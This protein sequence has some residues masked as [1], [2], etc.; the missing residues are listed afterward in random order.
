MLTTISHELP[1]DLQAKPHPVQAH[2]YEHPDSLFPYCSILAIQHSENKCR[3]ILQLNFVGISTI[4]NTV[5]KLVMN[6]THWENITEIK[7]LSF[8]YRDV[9]RP[10][11]IC[12]SNYIIQLRITQLCQHA[13]NLNNI[14]QKSIEEYSEGECHFMWNY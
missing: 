3:N 5:G 2:S 14:V 13:S 1:Q 11:Q 7:M 8:H 4:G 12:S 9:P 10:E 6:Y